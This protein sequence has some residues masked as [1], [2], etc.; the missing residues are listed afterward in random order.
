MNRRDRKAWKAARALDD[1]GE[2]VIRWLNGEITQTPSHMGPPAAETI[3]L[4]GE[5]TVMNRGGLITVNS[6]RAGTREDRAWTAWVCGFANDAV[7]L[8]LREAV[9]GT[10]LTLCACRQVHHECE[11]SG[12][13]CCC[14][15]VDETRFWSERCPSVADDLHDSWLVTV[16]DPE[17]GRNE[18][19]WPALAYALSGETRGCWCHAAHGQFMIAMHPDG[20]CRLCAAQPGS[21][22]QIHKELAS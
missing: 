4:I 11:Q 7:L 22:E 17:P 9:K 6:Q 5:L 12:L 2:T 14:P 19:L 3:P 20:L 15:W 8:I 1:L 10:P 16:E 21:C 13:W 18:L